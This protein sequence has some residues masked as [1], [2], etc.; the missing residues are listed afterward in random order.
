MVYGFRAHSNIRYTETTPGYASNNRPNPIDMDENMLWTW[1]PWQGKR[2]GVGLSLSR[3]LPIVIWSLQV[4]HLDFHKRLENIAS[5]L[6]VSNTKVY[7]TFKTTF[8]IMVCIAELNQPCH[9]CGHTW[10]SHYRSTTYTPVWLT[11][12]ITGSTQQHR[13]K[14][15]TTILITQQFINSSSPIGCWNYHVSN[16]FELGSQFRG[17]C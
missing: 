5:A 12:S 14:N 11:V 8:Y 10:W 9:D 7:C 2:W 15:T 3:T 1:L 16:G 17:N 4:C 6:D 13:Q